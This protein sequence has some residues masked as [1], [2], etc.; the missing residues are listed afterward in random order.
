MESH[1]LLASQDNQSEGIDKDDILDRLSE[2]IERQLLAQGPI[3]ISGL[4]TQFD[5]PKSEVEDCVEAMQ[6]L[7]GLIAPC[8]LVDKTPEK[9]G[10]YKILEEIGRGGMGV[11]YRAI[12][13]SLGREVAVKVLK[14][15][16]T[17]EGH[18]LERFQREA[19]I[20]ARLNHPHIVTIHDIQEHKGL[21]YIV[22]D[23]IRGESLAD[24]LEE[25]G[26]LSLHQSAQLTLQIAEAL[27]HAHQRSV[28]HRDVK[29]RNVI[30]NEQGQV[31]LTDFGLA[32]MSDSK[33]RGITKTGYFMGTL[34]YAAPEQVLGCWKNTDARADVYALG[35]T[36]YHMLTGAPPF[37][38]LPDVAKTV[39]IIE[40]NPPRPSEIRGD[41]FRGHPLE[42]LC[43]KC[44]EK[45]PDHRFQ[46]V[47][48]IIQCLREYF[49]PET[50][51]AGSLAPSEQQKTP[52]FERRAVS[53][54][55]ILLAGFLLGALCFSLKSQDALSLEKSGQSSNKLE[56]LLG[57]IERDEW[58]RGPE[59][60]GIAIAYL[61]RALQGDEDGQVY[62][63]LKRIQRTLEEAEAGLWQELEQPTFGEMELGEQ[64]IVGLPVALRSTQAR[65]PKSPLAQHQRALE[66]AQR[67][68]W[69]RRKQGEGGRTESRG[70]FQ[71]V[72][73]ARQSAALRRGQIRLAGL[74]CQALVA[75]KNPEQAMQAL[76]DYLGAERDEKRALVGALSL[77]RL[78]G[79]LTDQVIAATRLRVANGALFDHRLDSNSLNSRPPI[80]SAEEE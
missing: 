13:P 55:L 69:S 61:T 11:V 62:G 50:D 32:K 54:L 60:D 21:D 17:V 35:T 1:E 12:Q 51:S 64:R 75:A 9:L 42:A 70:L 73:V 74:I 49:S 45:D 34:Q 46:S 15:S 7:T 3:S 71:R 57:R 48:E 58:P 8:T 2:V 19:K 52:F 14:R 59:S 20:I 66:T 18:S 27:S 6:A 72:V 41:L 77:Q 37:A 76:R 33:A 44:L 26:V 67:R 23:L 63:A 5:L 78:G 39:A 68:L 56:A 29:P 47:S 28:L 24:Y 4:S 79:P 80:Q 31:L 40:E 53:S 65:F 10:P 36:L 22:M 38:E 25:K 16:R 30:F 43:L